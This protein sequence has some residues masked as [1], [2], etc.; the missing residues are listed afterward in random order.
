[1]EDRKPKL[2]T[3]RGI[4][5]DLIDRVS[6]AARNSGMTL[7]AW[8]S[9][10]LEESISH[11]HQEVTPPSLLEKEKLS[12]R[13]QQLETEVEHLRG[14][15]RAWSSRISALTEFVADR[16]VSE[17]STAQFMTYEDIENIRDEENF[18]GIG[19]GK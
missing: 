7:G 1:M 11:Y 12:E 8:V 13:V 6:L 3:V 18:K 10:A 2:W 17:K 15:V 16:K 9:R 4:S 19:W 14:A 5:P